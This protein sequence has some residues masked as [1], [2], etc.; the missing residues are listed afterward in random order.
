MSRW[1]P[2]I[3]IIILHWNV[4]LLHV[5]SRRYIIYIHLWQT[6]WAPPLSIP[7]MIQTNVLHATAENVNDITDCDEAALAPDMTGVTPL[8]HNDGCTS[9]CHMH[10]GRWK[11]PALLVPA[12]RST[13]KGQR[14]T[15]GKRYTSQP[16]ENNGNVLAKFN[17]SHLH[18]SG[19]NDW[20]PSAHDQL[21][22]EIGCAGKINFLLGNMPYT[23]K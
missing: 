7:T 2:A 22:S 17:Y 11:Y 8:S 9:E 12:P 6:N 20:Y 13:D 21:H 5:F 19:M 1:L 3:Q 15:E 18:S 10:Y 14:Q 4:C 16:I 23:G